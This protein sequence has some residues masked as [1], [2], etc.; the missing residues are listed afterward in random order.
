MPPP[1]YAVFRATRFWTKVGE[2]SMIQIPP[3][4]DWSAVFDTILFLRRMGLPA[5]LIATPPPRPRVQ[6]W[7][8]IVFPTTKAEEPLSRLMPPPQPPEELPCRL[9]VIVLLRMK[10]EPPATSI[11]PPTAATF[12]V[13]MLLLMVGDEF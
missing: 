2:E 9:A 7:L 4:G 12:A 1:K 10:G 6:K 5:M 13:I 11:P 3:P 8:E